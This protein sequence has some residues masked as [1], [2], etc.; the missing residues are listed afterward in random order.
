MRRVQ[1]PFFSFLS[2]DDV[3][4]PNFYASVLPGF[5]AHPQA[6]MSIGSTLEFGED[7]E[8]LYAP[9][10]LWKRNGLYAAPAGA[11][12]MLSNRHP[13]WTSIVFRRELLDSI[14]FLDLQVGPPADLDYELRAAARFP[15]V[16]TFE[17]CGAYVRHAGAA[18][19]RED[20][21]IVSGFE[22]IISNLV[23]DEHIAL[24]DRKRFRSRLTKQIQSKLLE[25]CVKSLLRGD[26]ATSREAAATLGKRYGRRL[27]EAT[28]NAMIWAYVHFGVARALLRR[29]ELARLHFRARTS[30]KGQQSKTTLSE[31]SLRAY[32]AYVIGADEAPQ[33]NSL[34]R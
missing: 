31:T 15:I 24:S 10:A 34:L 13:T 2:D 12:E 18:S 8:L 20:T 19:I 14:G 7:G 11:F 23:S 4:F 29:V 32:A 3:L 21:R 30:R 27:Q 6:M 28:L 17:P 9:L 16:V 5:E 26:D 25:I 1:T 22:K 33:V